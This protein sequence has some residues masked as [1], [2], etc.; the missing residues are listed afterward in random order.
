[1]DAEKQLMTCNEY[2]DAYQAHPGMLALEI[3]ILLRPILDEEGR[4]LHNHT[5]NKILSLCPDRER[6]LIDLARTVIQHI[7][8]PNERIT[9]ATKE[10]H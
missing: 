7:K 1:M 2:R 3:A 4:G 9:D 5:T 10:D 6:L 8:D